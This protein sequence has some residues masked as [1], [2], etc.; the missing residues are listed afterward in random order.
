VAF[1]TH[2]RRTTTERCHFPF[3]DPV[4]V[5]PSAVGYAVGE[6]GDES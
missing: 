5:F 1:V 2:Q 3:L 6:E 4:T